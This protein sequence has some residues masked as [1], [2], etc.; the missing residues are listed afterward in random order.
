MMLPGGRPTVSV[1]SLRAAYR[2]GLAGL[3]ALLWAAT[4]FAAGQ[5]PGTLGRIA[6]AGEIRLGY[7]ESSVP[8]SYV[9]PDGQIQGYSYALMRH[10]AEALQ[11]TLRQP[12][13]AIR[14]IPITSQNRIRMVEEGRID[15]ECG[16]TTHTRDR[17]R[18]VGFSTTIFIA[19]TRLLTR[20]D[21]G[22]ADFD[23]LTGRRVVTTA[24]TTSERWLHRENRQH[25]RN[26]TLLSARDH[27]DGFLV[28]NARLA[29]AYMLDD[30]L[31]H[32]ERARAPDPDNWVVTGTPRNFEAYACMFAHNDLPFKQAVDAA[33]LRLM[34]SGEALRLYEQWF[35]R[36]IP[37]GGLNLALPLSARMQALF[38]APD[39]TPFE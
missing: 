33:L 39:D 16:S 32:G 2:H 18:R 19:S 10:V 22:I 31:L 28:L 25:Q 14:L 4:T 12:E 8:F 5:W 38:A 30:A 35:N 21:S 11:K 24:G 29:D 15:L 34:A 13:L 17:A 36:P 37:P 3:C 27:R 20:R 23:D 26:M 7:R 6:Q 9:T 1:P